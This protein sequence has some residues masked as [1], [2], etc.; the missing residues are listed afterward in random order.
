M[1]FTNPLPAAAVG[2]EVVNDLF[3]VI[4][5]LRI[6]FYWTGSGRQFFFSIKS[7]IYPGVSWSLF[8]KLL[9]VCF[10]SGTSL[11]K[12]TLYF[13]STLEVFYK[14]FADTSP[15]ANFTKMSEVI[16]EN[17]VGH[18]SCPSSTVCNKFAL[19]RCVYVS[20]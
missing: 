2:G 6:Y 14:V 3:T 11:S 7:R 18:V 19:N 15:V 13:R 9:L 17:I 12:L 1:I 20:I 16:L 5:F 4:A 8:N 10:Q